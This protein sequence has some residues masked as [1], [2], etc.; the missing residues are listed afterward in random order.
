MCEHNEM[1]DVCVGKLEEMMDMPAMSF[2][3]SYC[4]LSFSSSHL[5]IYNNFIF[6]LDCNNFRGHCCC[7]IIAD[8]HVPRLYDLP[9]IDN[10]VSPLRMDA[11]SLG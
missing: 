1:S 10:G 3:V 6:N 8:D 4:K 2:Q 5:L 11:N 7:N 9:K